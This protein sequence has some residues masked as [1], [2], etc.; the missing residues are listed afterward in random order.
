MVTQWSNFGMALPTSVLS[1]SL[2]TKIA[3]LSTT[4]KSWS[5]FPSAPMWIIGDHKAARV[6]L[7]TISTA[8]FLQPP[9]V[10]LLEIQG[11]IACL[12]VKI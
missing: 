7:T 11:L 12:A 1:E 3:F 4:W 6:S 2:V 5:D 8:S 10:L 9:Q